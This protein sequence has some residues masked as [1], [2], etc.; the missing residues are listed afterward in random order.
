[1]LKRKDLK[2]G[3]DVLNRV[4]GRIGTV[5]G[6]PKKPKKLKCAHPSFV[7]VGSRVTWGR[8]RKRRKRWAE[9][10]WSIEHLEVVA[11]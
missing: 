4:S 8:G 1:M 2:P 11:P 10:V 9:T 6:D 5:L 3:M 7:I